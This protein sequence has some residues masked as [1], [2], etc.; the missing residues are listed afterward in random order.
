[1][2]IEVLYFAAV[3]EL[4]GLEREELPLPAGVH[5]VGELSAHL[6][7]RHDGLRGRLGQV[8]FAVN[9]QFA[10][11]DALVNDGDVV[12]LIPPVA[13]GSDRRPAKERVAIRGEPLSFDAVVDLVRHPGA[14]ALA[15]FVGVVRDHNDGREVSALEYS[16][17]ES[18]AVAEMARI[19][20][21]I[22]AEIPVVRLA[23]H[24]RVGELAVGDEAVICA[25]SSPHRGEAFRAG[26]ALIDRIKERVPIWKREKGPDGSYWVGWED[27]RCAPGHHHA[28][29][30]EPE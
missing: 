19:V 2:T 24:H 4:T 5:T 25:A 26:R 29:P 9:E 30:H 20:E 14:G 7:A 28:G 23:A 8:R 27:A 17:Y 12:A 13:G 10:P 16:A 11:H 3:R 21:A 18:M 15:T 6:E 1:M 22:E